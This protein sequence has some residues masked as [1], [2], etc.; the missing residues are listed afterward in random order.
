[1]PK[2]FVYD[3]AGA[4]VG[5][6]ELPE[7]VFGIEHNAVATAT[8]F[9]SWYMSDKSYFNSFDKIESKK[10]A[11]DY[12]MLIALREELNTVIEEDPMGMYFKPEV[13]NKMALKY[14][15][16]SEFDA[17]ETSA[18]NNE[19][20]LYSYSNAAVPVDLKK[21]VDFE[22]NH[23]DN[24]YYVTIKWYEDPMYLYETKTVEYPLEIYPNNNLILFHQ[25]QQPLDDLPIPQSTLNL[26]LYN[27]LHQLDANQ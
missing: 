1:M 6:I 23:A 14:F 16:C 25:F 21:V 19:T 9:A 15:N 2:T 27:Q 12:L 8:Y 24:K 22:E 17:T 5:E 11:V 3:M 13:I 18:Y 4:K 26:L 10:A 7:S 20:N